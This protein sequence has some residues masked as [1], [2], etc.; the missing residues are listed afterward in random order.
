VGG[1]TGGEFFGERGG[2]SPPPTAARAAP[3]PPCSSVLALCGYILSVGRTMRAA[4]LGMVLVV[5]TGA[6]SRSAGGQVLV[7][8]W[9]AAPRIEHSPFAAPPM[10]FDARY[11]EPLARSTLV[12][13]FVGGLIVGGVA[14][15]AAADRFDNEPVVI[16]YAVGSAAG[17]LLATAARESPRPVTILLGTALGALPLLAIASA[18]REG[19]FAVPVLLVGAVTTPLLGAV[20]QRW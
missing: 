2:S 16:T 10:R 12:E 14:G 8:S 1:E 4:L 17:V 7:S 9:H 19:P 13:R 20:G 18:E 5:A 11:A 15:L 3:W 6:A